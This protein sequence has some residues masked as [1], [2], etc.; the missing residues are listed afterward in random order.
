[1]ISKHKRIGVL[2]GGLSAEREVSLRSGENV[3]EALKRRGYH[4]ARLI[5]DD[6][7]QIVEQLMSVDVVFNCLHGGVGEDGTIQLLLELLNRPYTGSRPLACALAMDKLAAKREFQRAGLPTPPH[8]EHRGEGWEEWARVVADKLGFPCVVKPVREGSSVGVHIVQNTAELI[9]AAQATQREYGELFVEGFIE[10][11]EITAGI[12]RIDGE[13]RALSLIELRAKGQFYDY[14]AKYT[15]GL[16]EFVIPARLD[17]E[18]TERVQELSLKAHQ[19]LGCFGYSRVDLRVTPEGEPFVLEVNTIPGMTE[20]SDL[21]KAAAAAGIPFD[22][23][24]ER[25]LETAG[26]VDRAIWRTKAG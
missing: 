14:Q 12:L 2:M 3:Y 11:K 13:D 17:E 26:L 18:T 15:P 20:T 9:E 25:M 21:P 10:G 8:V 4:A 22:E 24:V 6:A 19:A 1:M 5:F 16:T 7:D 23:L